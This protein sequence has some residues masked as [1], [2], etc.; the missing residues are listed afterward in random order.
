[1]LCVFESLKKVVMYC[2]PIHEKSYKNIYKNL[3][4]GVNEPYLWC[5]THKYRLE[6]RG[7]FHPA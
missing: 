4:F 2:I 5:K 6:G 1:M 3:R 7:I